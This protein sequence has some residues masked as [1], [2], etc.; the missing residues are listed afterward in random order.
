M[1]G[2]LLRQP[3][4]TNDLLTF[5]ACVSYPTHVFT[6]SPTPP[7]LPPDIPSD[8]FV[9]ADMDSFPVS[10]LFFHRCHIR[11]KQDGAASSRENFEVKLTTPSLP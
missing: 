5:S 11:R 3:H 9:L 7:L 6:E 1:L 8:I 2:K 10:L 4:S